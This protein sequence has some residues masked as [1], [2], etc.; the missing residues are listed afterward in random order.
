MGNSDVAGKFTVTR[1]IKAI[2]RSDL[3]SLLNSRTAADM[4]AQTVAIAISEKCLS[5]TQVSGPAII[6]IL[7]REETFPPSK[8]A[9]ALHLLTN[10]SQNPVEVRMVANV[11]A[12]AWLEDW[13]LR[14]LSLISGELD[15]TLM[16]LGGRGPEASALGPPFP[17]LK[18]LRLEKVSPMDDEIEDT[19]S[20]TV[21]LRRKAGLTTLSVYSEVM[22]D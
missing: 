2:K 6:S 3:S 20:R 5:V 12:L 8:I 19:I 1:L 22:N 16:F 9:T 17:L 18:A 13:D 21:Q 14:K 11:E 4:E 7:A 10:S 15:S